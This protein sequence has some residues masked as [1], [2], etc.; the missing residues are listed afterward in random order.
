M[1]LLVSKYTVLVLLVVSG[2]LLP[3]VALG[4]GPGNT[5]RSPT[6]VS[7]NVLSV[8]VD[9]FVRGANGAP[10]PGLVLVTLRSSRGGV[11]Q[12]A[13][14]QAGRVQFQ[15]VT[16][17][18]YTVQVEASGFDRAEQEIDAGGGVG[19]SVF[20]EM[21]P[22]SS[23]VS[24][25]PV[26]K[27]GFPILTPKAERHLGKALEALRANKPAEA[28]SHL[29]EAQRLAPNHPEVDYLFGVYWEQMRDLEQTKAYFIKAINAYPSHVRALIS[30]SEVLLN[31]G[32]NDDAQGYLKRA[33]ESEPNSWSAHAMLAEASSRTGATDEA[34]RQAERALELAHGQAEFVEPILARALAKRGDKERA[35]HILQTY[36]Q[37]HTQDLAAKKLLD[38]LKAPEVMS[39]SA[40]TEA[41]PVESK[42]LPAAELA[43]ALPV[44]SIWMPPGVDDNVPP[45]EPGAVCAMDEVLRNAAKRVQE[46]VRNADR[47][48]ATE[49]LINEAIDKR[50]L[51]SSPERRRFDYVVSIAEVRRGF[52]NVE[53]YR[54][55]VS[56]QAEFPDGVITNGLPALI[57]IFH[58]FNLESF[59]M[60]CEGLA[61]WN[62]G[63]AWQVHFRQRADKPNTVR[64]Y[65]LGL[66]GVTYPI[67]LKGRAWIAAD[68]YQVVRLE[69]D[70]VAPIPEI[71]LAADHTTI[72]YAPV[73]FSA[74]KV[75]M[76]LP[77]SAEVFYDWRGRRIHRRHSFSEYL[78]FSVDD[79]QRVTTPKIEDQAPTETLP[80][81]TKPP[82]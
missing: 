1:F 56:S 31:E 36:L 65:K 74:R 6:A 19:A 42:P 16:P 13:S 71:R 24:A 33:V 34:I 21:R 4:Q 79:K 40:H 18:R 38:S 20:I 62:G 22:A 26:A 7:G 46:F 25:A 58:P 63:L 52:F 5:S 67:A 51:A 54:R 12:Q 59:E 35:K 64:S 70:L 41:A 44:A 66:N 80:E 28:R 57:L 9:V 43:A 68:T 81:T 50:G 49:S 75:D 2:A 37:N 73:H 39:S 53:E 11:Y 72:D 78:L 14:A 29:D 82:K 60:S 45:V 32:K 3:A 69:T 61:R 48:T 8:S 77:Q 17:S 30:L 23:G 47:F 27:S 10:L 76:W 55:S 15:D